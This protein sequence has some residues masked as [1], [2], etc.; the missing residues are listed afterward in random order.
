[1]PDAKRIKLANKELEESCQQS[2]ESAQLLDRMIEKKLQEES[3]EDEQASKD[4]MQ[5]LE[6]EDGDGH[7]N[8]M[9]EER[10]DS[11][12]ANNTHSLEVASLLDSYIEE[13]SQHNDL[14]KDVDELLSELSAN[15]SSHNDTHHHHNMS[16]NFI[17]SLTTTTTSTPDNIPS[18]SNDNGNS[19]MDALDQITD[20]LDDQMLSDIITPSNYTNSSWPQLTTNTSQMSGGGGGGSSEKWSS[21]N[22]FN[23]AEAEEAVASIMDNSNSMLANGGEELPSLDLSGLDEMQMDVQI[24]CAIKSIMMSS[25][26]NVDH[27]GGGSMSSASS[28]SM[29]HHHDHQ[30]QNH[31]QQQQHQYQ[32]HQTSGMM[33]NSSNYMSS[34]HNHS[35]SMRATMS[36]PSAPV[37]DPMLDEA[38][39]SILG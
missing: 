38:V 25:P 36:F 24:D 34:Y 2:N 13:N 18:S 29:H 3:Q 6:A 12:E 11:E 8:E 39:K 4:L 31:H 21:I 32:H 17:N 33:N 20:D 35:Q 37:N 27:G 15:Y 16:D 26:T 10:K 30:H 23:E 22:R 14:G 28:I 9:A 1:M 5:M 7:N 19:F